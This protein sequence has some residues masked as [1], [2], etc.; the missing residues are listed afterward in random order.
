MTEI[1]KPI[2]GYHYEMSSLGNV[3]NTDTGRI[4]T[5]RVFKN[6]YMYVGLWKSNVEKRAY[7]HRLMAIAFIPNDNPLNTCIDHIDGN[8]S[9]N[10][11]KNLRWCTQQQN[12]FNTKIPT[13]NTSGYKGVIWDKSRNKWC[14][15][16]EFNGKRI[17][18]GRFETIEEARDVRQA[19]ARELFG[20]FVH[21]SESI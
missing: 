10:C 7:I 9:N 11:L 13:T 12:V 19:K 5:N 18:L 15:S 16:I 1:W 8:P 21:S 4:L 3:R 2:D 6:G 20:E 17:N 14:A